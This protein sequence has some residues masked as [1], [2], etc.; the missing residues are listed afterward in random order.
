MTEIAL[1]YRATGGLYVLPK[2]IIGE[3]K[4]LGKQF[5]KTSINRLGEVLYY[6]DV[7]GLTRIRYMMKSYSGESSDLVHK[8]L[9]TFGDLFNILIFGGVEIELRDTVLSSRCTLK[10]RVSHWVDPD[11]Q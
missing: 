11:N 4:D 7:S 1:S 2:V 6:L 5:Q 3:F 9:D 10:F 8:R